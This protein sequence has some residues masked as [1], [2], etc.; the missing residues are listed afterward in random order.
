MFFSSVCKEKAVGVSLQVVLSAMTMKYDVMCSRNVIM[1]L[2]VLFVKRGK[3]KGSIM[4]F[5]YS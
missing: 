5:G 1:D 3:E 2:I 4:V